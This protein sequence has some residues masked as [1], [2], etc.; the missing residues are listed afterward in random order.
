MGVSLYDLS[1]ASYLQVLGGVGGFLE[2][3]L[4][5]C[6]DNNIDPNSFVDARVFADML[7][8]QFQ[9]NSVAHHSLGAIEGIK[10][11]LFA[12]PPPAPAQDYRALQKVIADTISQL[13]PGM[14]VPP[15]LD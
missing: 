15:R 4:K 11:G 3:G 6:T 2:K 1:V 13:K 7:P 5:H 8:F 14:Q 10:K 12:P 9:V